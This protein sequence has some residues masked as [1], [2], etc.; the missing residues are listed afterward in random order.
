MIDDFVILVNKN[1]KKIG[2][3]PKMEAHKK[4]A[5]HRAFSVFIFNN[6]NEL[7][8]QKRNINKYH[9]PGLWTNTC[10]SHQK[11]GE[12]NINAGKRRLLEEMGFCVELN[13]IGSFI[14]NVGVDNGL[15]EH[16]LDYILVGKY[17]GNVK[18]NSDEVD[19]WKWMSLDNIKDDV[20]K[21]SKNY[22]EWFKIIM[23][24]YYTQ[25]KKI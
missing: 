4:G 19:N 16:E 23:D 25:L 22:T 11:D 2:L 3:M 5:L 21:R 9:S 24:N 17:N 1:D 20:R 12:S 15:I 7:M 14:Y 8:I 10:C 18:I 6:K 13:E